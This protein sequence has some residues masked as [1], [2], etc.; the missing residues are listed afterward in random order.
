MQE[1]RR[2]IRKLE[3]GAVKGLSAGAVPLG[4]ADVDGT[5]PW[6]GLPRG[7]L[8]E[9]LAG[10]GTDG[11]QGP[12]EATASGFCAALLGRM[13][14]NRGT[15]LWCRRGRNLYGPGL[16]AFGLDPGRLI[17]VRGRTDTDILWAM[18]EGL[19]SGTPAAILG[20][21]GRIPPTA[22][23][24]LQLAAESG[25]VMALLLRSGTAKAVPSPA[26]TRW[27]V[28]PMPTVSASPK[29]PGPP[30]WRLELL[31]C[32]GGMPGTWLVEWRDDLGRNRANNGRQHD[33]AGGF[34]LAA[35]VR[36]R[37]DDAAAFGGA[38]PENRLAV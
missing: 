9:V 25:G 13:A 21:V 32:R 34:A 1:L 6:G 38:P 4:I 24:R 22:L 28:E 15:V 27:L 12:A 20:E 8:N 10:T 11:G 16:A 7:A 30:R 23:R 31:R 37:P 14:G 18:E 33:K 2:R 3:R 5:L 17:I 35:E 29:W 19:R 36:Q 26:M